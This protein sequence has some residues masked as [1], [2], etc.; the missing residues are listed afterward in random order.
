MSAFDACRGLIQATLHLVNSEFDA[1]AVDIVVLGLPSLGT[2]RI[3]GCRR[4]LGHARFS[5]SCMLA[6]V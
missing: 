6:G 5:V 1:L 2:D 4:A 3:R